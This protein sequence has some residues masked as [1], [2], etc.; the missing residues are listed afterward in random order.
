MKPGDLVS[1]AQ[2]CIGMHKTFVS[3]ELGIITGWG[4]TYSGVRRNDLY[5]VMFPSGIEV[6]AEA[7]LELVNEIG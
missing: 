1:V 7:L 2:P 4:Q 6:F 5:R 3:G